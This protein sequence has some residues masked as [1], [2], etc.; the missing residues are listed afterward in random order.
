MF[1]RSDTWPPSPVLCQRI[2]SIWFLKLQRVV[3]RSFSTALP[4]GVCGCASDRV[5][6]GHPLD[7]GFAF[8]VCQK[9]WG[10]TCFSPLYVWG[11]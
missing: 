2:S 4:E 8:P 3:A 1:P 7:S 9:R 11:K 5:S 6:L 10:K